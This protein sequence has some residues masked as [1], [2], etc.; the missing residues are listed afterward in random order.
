MFRNL[1]LLFLPLDGGGWVGVRK[2]ATH[3]PLTLPIKGG[4]Y[5][6]AEGLINLLF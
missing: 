1:K 2:K 3:P 6:I 4:E 5:L